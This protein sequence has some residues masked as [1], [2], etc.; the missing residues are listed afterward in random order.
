MPGNLSISGQ[1]E[2]ANGFMVNGSLVE[3]D[4]NNGTV[5]VPNL[6]SIQEL[7]VLTNNFDAQYG[8]FSGGQVLVNTKSGT[9]QIHGS[10][11]EF[12][13]NTGLDARN[14]FAHP[15]APLTTATSTAARWAA[16]FDKNKAY[17][18]LDYQGTQMTQGQETGNIVVPSLADRSGNLCRPRQPADRQGQ[19]RLLG[20]PAIAK[21][22]LHGQRG[23]TLLHGRLQR[24]P[25]SVCFP[26]AKIPSSIWSAPAKALLQY[27]PQAERRVR[28]SSPAPRKTKPSATTKAPPASM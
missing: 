26:N 2:T 20:Q 12:L 25:P 1:R 21:T 13:R 8:N 19:Q 17:F 7:R 15:N 28:T 4:F 10:V 24:M 11:F 16:R 22:R 6:D 23:R 5:I 18:F 3:E 9:N 14:Y 27:I